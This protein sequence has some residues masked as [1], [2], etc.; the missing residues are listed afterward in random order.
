[1]RWNLKAIRWRCWCSSRQPSHLDGLFANRVVLLSPSTSNKPK[2]SQ[3]RRIA[4]LPEPDQ[5]QR[6][7]SHELQRMYGSDCM[8]RRHQAFSSLAHHPAERAQV[9]KRLKPESNLRPVSWPLRSTVT[10]TARKLVPC[11]SFETM[12]LCTQ[13]LAG[14]SYEHTIESDHAWQSA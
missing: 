2:P 14:P 6:K 11:R 4:T 8:A 9:S 10:H 3:G 1:M 7:L 13:W 12:F 5:H